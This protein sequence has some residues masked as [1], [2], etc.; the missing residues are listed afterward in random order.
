MAISIYLFFK[1]YS[2]S[3]I[4]LKIPKNL[5]FLSKSIKNNRNF[6][7]FSKI[8]KDQNKNVRNFG[9]NEKLLRTFEHFGTKFSG[10]L[11][12]SK[13]LKIFKNLRNPLKVY[14]YFFWKKNIIV[15]SS[16]WQS[17]TNHQKT[18]TDPDW[19]HLQKLRIPFG[20]YFRWRS[21][22]YGKAVLHQFLFPRIRSRNWS[23]R[24]N[25]KRRVRHDSSSRHPWR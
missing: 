16:W 6:G 11:K 24:F 4:Q 2:P 3:G 5:K 20:A 14:T 9:Q 8:F 19:S 17:F 18:R 13:P 7:I 22:T 15:F 21:R 12:F 10:K 25:Q 23:W 1:W